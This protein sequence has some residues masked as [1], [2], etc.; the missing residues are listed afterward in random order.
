MS[1]RLLKDEPIVVS[2]NDHWFTYVVLPKPNNRDWSKLYQAQAQN[3][4]AYRNYGLQ[5]QNSL[6]PD[7]YGCLKW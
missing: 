3:V 6:L 1:Y 5:Q 2:R 4:E 7:L